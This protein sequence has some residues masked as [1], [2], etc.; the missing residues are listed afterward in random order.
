MDRFTLNEPTPRSTVRYATDIKVGQ[1]ARC[2]SNG[3]C[4]IYYRVSEGSMILF[5]NDVVGANVEAVPYSSVT[6]IPVSALSKGTTVT[7]TSTE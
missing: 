6:G 4:T 5:R 7:F 1:M 2:D 3:H